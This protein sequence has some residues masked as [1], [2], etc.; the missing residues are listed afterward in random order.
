MGRADIH[1]AEHDPLD[2]SQLTHLAVLELKVLRSFSEGGASYSDRKNRT[3]VEDGIKQAG[4][5][6]QEHRH[7]VAALC[8]FD[9]RKEDTGEEC[10]EPWRTLAVIRSVALKRWYLFAT[11]KASARCMISA[12]V[13]LAREPR[14]TRQAPSRLLAAP[15]SAWNGTARY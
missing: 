11:S 4:A 3:C 2:H 12:G 13:T 6:R 14:A 5:Y 8:C 10:F 1:I 7:R 9:M 15:R